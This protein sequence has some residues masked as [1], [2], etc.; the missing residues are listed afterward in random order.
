MERPLNKI[1]IDDTGLV[2]TRHSL[3]LQEN[4]HVHTTF[5]ILY[6]G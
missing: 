4:L 2:G 3:L 5:V 1:K 6:L